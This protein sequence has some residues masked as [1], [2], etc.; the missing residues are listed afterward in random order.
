MAGH[1][2]DRV[3]ADLLQLISDYRVDGIVYYIPKYCE[4]L[5]LDYPA[6]YKKLDELSIPI[7]RLEGE[8]AGDLGKTDL[9]SFVEMIELKKE[10]AESA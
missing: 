7:K 4:N 6:I 1:Q 9:R 3:L 2:S 8:I 10:M 5:Y